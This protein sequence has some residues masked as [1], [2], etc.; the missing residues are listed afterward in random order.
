MTS[1]L[2]NVD[3]VIKFNEK[4]QSLALFI[5]ENDKGI[6]RLLYSKSCHAK[7]NMTSVLLTKLFN[8]RELNAAQ[9][10]QIVGGERK[11]KKILAKA[12]SFLPNNKIKSFFPIFEENHL[13]FEPCIRITKLLSF[14]ELLV[15]K[16]RKT[17]KQYAKDC[18]IIKIGYI[19]DV[20]Q[21]G[22]YHLENDIW[23]LSETGNRLFLTGVVYNQD[24]LEHWNMFV[25]PQNTNIVCMSL[26]ILS[27]LP[28]V[29]SLDN[30]ENTST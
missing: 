16:R 5:R 7:K 17:R 10:A 27:P 21:D 20:Q 29:A 25:N 26:I 4:E 15:F 23:I 24:N 9:I 1:L 28:G 19:F 11:V 22:S 3:I 12:F 2:N 8:S 6:D 18:E 13:L 14:D 30:T